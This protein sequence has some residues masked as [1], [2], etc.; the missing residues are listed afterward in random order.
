[1]LFRLAEQTIDRRK[2]TMVGEA[3]HCG[4]VGRLRLTLSVAAGR[5]VRRPIHP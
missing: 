1:M 2:R 4:L 3:Y 5:S